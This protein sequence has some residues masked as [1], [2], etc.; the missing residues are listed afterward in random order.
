MKGVKISNHNSS[1]DI[2]DHIK[3]SKLLINE[4]KS[5]KVFESPSDPKLKKY[6]V[7]KTDTSV[8]QD[9][10]EKYDQKDFHAQSFYPEKFNNQGGILLSNGTYQT[11]VKKS[12]SFTKPL[13]N[14]KSKS[15]LKES[16]PLYDNHE[17]IN[18]GLLTTVLNQTTSILS[19][20]NKMVTFGTNPRKFTNQHNLSGSASVTSTNASSTS[21][22]TST[23]NNDSE[24]TNNSPDNLSDSTNPEQQ[25]FSMIQTKLS[26]FSNSLNSSPHHQKN[27]T[28]ANSFTP[29]RFDSASRPKINDKL[30]PLPTAINNHKNGYSNLKANNN[31]S[32]DILETKF[33]NKLCEDI[34]VSLN[35]DCECADDYSSNDFSGDYSFDNELLKTPLSIGK[36]N[37]QH[38]LQNNQ[39]GKI[40]P[41][42]NKINNLEQ[43]IKLMRSNNSSNSN[44][45]SSG[46]SK[47]QIGVLV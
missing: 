37:Y 2:N 23:T 14:E 5:K 18:S 38:K 6:A 39:A 13:V 26:T 20:S 42:Q 3:D 10:I 19:D 27:E 16:I 46:Q 40:N 34:E 7:F 25:S 24:Y 17:D 32:S 30:P 43:N 31:F 33:L 36:M 45:P 28:Y 12:I 9:K 22:A 11:R 8:P 4:L 21:P 44:Y 29:N 1:Y 41:L 15:D 35:V 47:N